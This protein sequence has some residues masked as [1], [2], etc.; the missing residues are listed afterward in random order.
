MSSAGETT[1]DTKETKKK[2]V[3]RR[4]VRK[5]IVGD[6]IIQEIIN[7][8]RVPQDSIDSYLLEP[9]KKIIVQKVERSSLPST[10]DYEIQERLIPGEN[11]EMRKVKVKVIK[12]RKTLSEQQKTDQFSNKSEIV[13]PTKIR[14]ES[15]NKNEDKCTEKTS[16]KRSA[17]SCDAESNDGNDH[18]K[19]SKCSSLAELNKLHPSKLNF[20]DKNVRKS[21]D[22]DIGQPL[23]DV[24]EPLD[25]DVGEPLNEDVGEPLDEDVGE[26]LDEDVGEPL[27]DEIGELI[28]DVGEPMEE[29]IGEKSSRNVAK[30]KDVKTKPQSNSKDKKSTKKS[31]SIQS[32][33][34]AYRA[35]RK[36]L[37]FDNFHFEENGLINEKYIA[38]SKPVSHKLT[39]KLVQEKEADI[40]NYKVLR[41]FELPDKK[42]DADELKNETSEAV[43]K[44][45]LPHAQFK[46]INFINLLFESDDS[47]VEKINKEYNTKI[48]LS[49]VGTRTDHS[50]PLH[51]RVSCTDLIN[52]ENAVNKLTHLINMELECYY[53]SMLSY[54]IIEETKFRDNTKLYKVITL[55]KKFLVYPDKFAKIIKKIP[56]SDSFQFHLTK[57]NEVH[58]QPKSSPS[59]FYQGINNI[60]KIIENEYL[61]KNYLDSIAL[62][63]NKWIENSNYITYVGEKFGQKPLCTKLYTE[64]RI[65]NSNSLICLLSKVLKH[66]QNDYNIKFSCDFIESLGKIKNDIIKLNYENIYVQFPKDYPKIDDFSPIE[67]IGDYKFLKLNNVSSDFLYA[68]I[69]KIKALKNDD[70]K[71]IWIRGS[72][73]FFFHFKGVNSLGMV[74]HHR[75]KC[76]NTEAISCQEV[77]KNEKSWK[78]F[79]QQLFWHLHY[80]GKMHQTKYELTETDNPFIIIRDDDRNRLKM[81]VN[82]VQNRIS[83]VSNGNTSIKA[84]RVSICR[85]S[86]ERRMLAI[87]RLLS[88]IKK[89]S[90]QYGCSIKIMNENTNEAIVDGCSDEQ[91][92][93]KI[94]SDNPIIMYMVDDYMN[95]VI[96]EE[97]LSETIG[98][99]SRKWSDD[100]ATLFIPIR[101]YDHINWT[102]KIFG[103]RYIQTLN[104]MD[105]LTVKVK[106]KNGHSYL[107][108]N[109]LKYIHPEM[110][111]TH[112]TFM[113]KNS[114][115]LLRT[116]YEMK[117]LI[118]LIIKEDDKFHHRYLLPA[119]YLRA[120]KAI[121]GDKNLV[122]ITTL[123]QTTGTRIHIRADPFEKNW[124][125][126]EPPHV[127]FESYDQNSLNCAV[128]TFNNWMSKM[129]LNDVLDHSIKIP[130]L[131][132][133]YTMPLNDLL[134]LELVNEVRG[135]NDVNICT[136]QKETGTNMVIINESGY[137]LIEAFKEEILDMAVKKV[138]VSAFLFCYSLIC[139]LFREII[140]ELSF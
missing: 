129:I 13:S 1:G 57:D 107:L 78:V 138:M 106:T 35:R 75:Y 5:K 22:D 14:I 133:R 89:T 25:E 118:N 127:Y 80:I 81:A 62:S 83:E 109:F 37:N 50:E 121:I 100:S 114:H 44:V 116:V 61:K 54:D 125:Y 8:E 117:C 28:N 33:I 119:K 76:K 45:I 66:S 2:I 6:K 104:F 93:I 7:E 110:I 10:E 69:E 59:C 134:S 17:S 9:Q 74:S 67:T 34:E 94:T 23:D 19:R 111:V 82:V 108:H 3:I 91:I 132:N 49:G 115:V 40:T 51:L 21:S 90:K 84:I 20:L 56:Q 103:H 55:S 52:C 140:I 58:V 97:L 98:V 124:F 77:K 18:N 95:T 122:G 30:P 101:V 113:S 4:I 47:F 36:E 71:S 86:T 85:L 46:V 112:I 42:D 29:D 43:L 27:E 79:R 24:E 72:N 53:R 65:S 99:I 130:E 63:C 87:K 139:L 38:K 131:K 31:D 26:P 64:N 128:N 15:G 60:K 12:I 126:D 39:E 135:P 48:V 92:L 32:R 73:N 16:I 137:L 96:N 136:I 105:D 88:E 102:Q 68:E 120:F 11:G 70:N 123:S 41:N